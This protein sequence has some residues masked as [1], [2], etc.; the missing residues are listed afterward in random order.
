MSSKLPLTTGRKNLLAASA[1]IDDNNDNG[2]GNGG[3]C[4][5][6]DGTRGRRGPRRL[7]SMRPQEQSKEKKPKRRSIR[8]NVLRDYDDVDNDCVDFI[9]RETAADRK[10]IDSKPANDD[11]IVPDDKQDANNYANLRHLIRDT[12]ATL[13]FSEL[14]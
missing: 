4:G 1:A 10:R 5:D 11:G 6:D 3:S 14:P 8:K 9:S 7:R 13:R 12:S 2:N